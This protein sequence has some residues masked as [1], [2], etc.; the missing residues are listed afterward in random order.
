MPVHD[1][2]C[3]NCD[4]GVPDQY[5]PYV[6]A[7]AVCPRCDFV[8]VRSWARDAR[9]MFK[10]FTVD[11][12]KGD[13][14]ITSLAQVREIERTSEKACA[15]GKESQLV[16]RHFS[17]DETNYDRNTLGDSKQKLPRKRPNITPKVLGP[18]GS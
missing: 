10:P 5:H 12:G 6:S 7:V 13:V 17:N 11:Y 2:I 4:L 9:P 1:W 16:F 15:A 18:G 14:E 8:M 3:E